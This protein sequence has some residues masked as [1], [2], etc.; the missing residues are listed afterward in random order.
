M[1]IQKLLTCFLS[2]ILATIGLLWTYDTQ[3]ADNSGTYYVAP[4]CTDV[5]TP[6]FTNIQAAINAADSEQDIIKVATG[7]YTD[8]Y[9][10]GNLQQV[11]YLSKT[12]ELQGGYQ[13]DNWEMPYPITQPTVLNAQRFG[14]VMYIIGSISPTIEGFQ[15]QSGD[16]YLY[17]R[18]PQTN[19]CGGGI[20]VITASATISGCV[21]AGNISNWGGGISLNASP[22]TLINNKILSNYA[23]KDGGGIHITSSPA[24]IISNTIH[25]N[26]IA[27]GNGGGVAIQGSRGINLTDN[28]ISL[29]TARPSDMY[30]NP[31]GAGMSIIAS[32][33]VLHHNIIQ[34]N[35][36]E[37]LRGDV[38]MGG[39][40][41]A[42]GSDLVL[43]ANTISANNATDGGGG[44]FHGGSATFDNN[45]I[46]DNIPYGIYS[47]GSSMI[48]RHNTIARNR[49]SGLTFDGTTKAVLTNTILV[50][51]T[52]G[53]RVYSSAQ[54]S[55]NATEWGADD[56]RNQT[57]WAAGASSS[58]FTGTLNLWND[59]M[60][61][62]PDS[63]DYHISAESEAHNNGVFVG[64]TADI[65]GDYRQDNCLVDIGADEFIGGDKCPYMF[66]LPIVWR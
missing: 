13:I 30:A 24:T 40:I 27:N 55:L 33:G 21:I 26:T 38:Y 8:M 46:T 19:C 42:L 45:F 65:D 35:N 54:V 1:V 51:H 18:D 15:L 20:R 14:R 2:I 58:F 63:G 41:Y 16:S 28:V 6:C 36:A 53:I 23:Y 9:Q 32:Q 61:V 4:N 49:I 22:T 5:P 57:D 66:C 60:F 10:V 52:V 37:H 44:Y 56:W 7:V 25:A 50:S 39:S 34:D 59:P 43:S 12:L 64:I 11:V 3:Q 17:D 47:K 29:N 31:N 62:N 48:F